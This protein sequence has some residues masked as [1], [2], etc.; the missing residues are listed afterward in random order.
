MYNNHD[1]WIKKVEELQEIRGYCH[2]EKEL[3]VIMS[4]NMAIGLIMSN[5]GYENY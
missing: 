2:P 4:L 5:L 1:F 3:D